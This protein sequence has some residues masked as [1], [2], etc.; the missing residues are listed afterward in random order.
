MYEFF[1]FFGGVLSYKFLSHMLRIKKDLSFF[2]RTYKILV[3]MT[4]FLLKARAE[5]VAQQESFYK[6]A[7]ISGQNTELLVNLADAEVMKI[8]SGLEKNLYALPSEYQNIAKKVIMS[9]EY[10]TYILEASTK[11]GAQSILYEIITKAENDE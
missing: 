2:M 8:Y 11:L 6:K 1:L 10:S 9:K 3:K 4:V 7:D 5:L